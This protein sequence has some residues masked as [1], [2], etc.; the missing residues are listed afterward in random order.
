MIDY[1]KPR[2]ARL[3]KAAER[4]V[5]AKAHHAVYA[6]VTARDRGCRNCGRI[7]GLH[8]HHLV[9]RS[10]GGET[11]SKNVI[12]L[13]DSCHARVHAHTLTIHVADAD[14]PLEFSDRSANLGGNT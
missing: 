6:A 2:S 5:I 11:T 9:F 3:I 8:R 1:P 14:G 10:R 12:V 13:C 7:W 4:R